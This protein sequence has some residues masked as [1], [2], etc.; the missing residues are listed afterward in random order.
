M[1]VRRAA[2]GLACLSVLGTSVSIATAATA[3]SRIQLVRTKAVLP[4]LA[5]AKRLGAAPS[6]TVLTVGLGLA[7]PNAPLEESL[8]KQLYPPSTPLY[9]H[10]LTPQQYQAHFAVPAATEHAAAAWLRSGGLKIET[11]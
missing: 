7:H 6:K 8:Y 3:T 10:F 2:V 11:V 4:G 1:N 9:R 5:N